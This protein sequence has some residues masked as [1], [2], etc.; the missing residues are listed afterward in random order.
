MQ[1]TIITWF[2]SSP[3]PKGGR[4]RLI[5][6]AD[7]QNLRDLECLIK[8]PGY[9]LVRTR[10]TYKSYKN[11]HFPFSMRE[12]L[13]IEKMGGMS[14]QTTTNKTL[15]SEQAEETLDREPNQTSPF[16]GWERQS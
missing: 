1:S 2:Q 16:A 9:F 6:P 10:L 5:M 8:I 13:E 7:L 11:N 3:A 12:G 4:N 14:G 15:L